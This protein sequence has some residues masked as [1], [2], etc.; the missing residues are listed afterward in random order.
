MVPVTRAGFTVLPPV[1]RSYR[2]MSVPSCPFCHSKRVF[3]CQLMP[4]LINILA[5]ERNDRIKKPMTHQERMKE[6]GKTLQGGTDGMEW[7]TCIIFSCE[8][9]C[10]DNDGCWREEVVLVQWDV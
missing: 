10:S 1:V 5:R 9:D 8:N 3:E 7:G 2:P 4:N 6:I